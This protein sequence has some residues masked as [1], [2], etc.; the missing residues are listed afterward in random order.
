MVQ[1]HHAGS[2]VLVHICV[3]LQRPIYI[4]SEQIGSH[5]LKHC[6]L[7]DLL[8][9]RLSPNGSR[10]PR[11][12]TGRH[13]RGDDI[14]HRH[15]DWVLDRSS[16]VRDLWSTTCIPGEHGSLHGPRHSVRRGQEPR[17]ADCGPLLFG[18]GGQCDDF[19]CAGDD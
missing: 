11:L 7:L 14:P 12:G 18:A 6:R 3:S 4:A 17:Y 10:V 13:H 5:L 19:E 9:D 16:R 1:D 15:C 2:G 8:H